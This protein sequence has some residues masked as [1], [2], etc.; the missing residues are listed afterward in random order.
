MKKRI[1]KV[2]AYLL[3]IGSKFST[4]DGRTLCRFC[5]ASGGSMR[6]LVRRFDTL[7]D[8]EKFVFSVKGVAK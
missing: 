5:G 8:L 1:E 7:E 3:R 2:N 6:F 4:E